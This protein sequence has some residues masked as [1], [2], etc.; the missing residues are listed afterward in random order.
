M[1]VCGEASPER[2]TFFRLQ[3]HERVGISPAEVYKRGW[4]N[5]SFGSVKG[6]KGL[7]DK[8]YGLEKSRKRSI[9]VIDSYLKDNT[10]TAV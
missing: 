10:F 3:V 2:A 6:P 1:V 4:G 5:L 7:T 8:F 9:F